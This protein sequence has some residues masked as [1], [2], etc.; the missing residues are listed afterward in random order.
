MTELAPPIQAQE[1]LNTPGPLT[2]AGLRGRVVAVA[3]FQMLCPG[4]VTHGLPQAQRI[5][6]T[7][8]DEDVAVIGLHCVFEHH[9]AMTPTALRAF[10]HEYR[11]RFPVA[12]DMPAD[13]GPLPRTMRLY[14]LEGTPSL[15]L[16]DRAGR[17]RARHFGA[18]P[19]MALGAEIMALLHESALPK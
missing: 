8:R 19:D 9:Q 17:L 7:F 5:A 13:P 2:L 6:Q 4:C 16:I 14:G 18:V 1:W 15:L 11:I 3:C 12:I 10:L